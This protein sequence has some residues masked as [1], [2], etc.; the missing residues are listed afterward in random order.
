M[1]IVPKS[2]SPYSH[3]TVPTPPQSRT[4]APPHPSV[5]TSTPEDFPAFSA[6]LTNVENKK[7]DI[8]FASSKSAESVS[9]TPASLSSSAPAAA[10]LNRAKVLTTKQTA[11]KNSSSFASTADD[12]APD[13]D[14]IVMNKAIKAHRVFAA[15]LETLFTLAVMFS[16]SLT[17]LVVF[18]TAAPVAM[19]A[20]ISSAWVFM[21]IPYVIAMSLLGLK[22]ASLFG[23]GAWYRISAA[24]AG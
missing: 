19:T 3:T 1:H 16:I 12:I 7:E 10:R 6:E 21:L 20:V 17:P 8:A 23:C 14:A 11:Q 24:F 4:V 18:Q 13:F 2:A 9:T 15:P 22:V 5:S